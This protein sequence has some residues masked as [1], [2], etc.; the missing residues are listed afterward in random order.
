MKTAMKKLVGSMVLNWGRRGAGVVEG[1]GGWW[2]G[3]REDPNLWE[4]FDDR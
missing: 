3:A 2:V 1:G 4:V